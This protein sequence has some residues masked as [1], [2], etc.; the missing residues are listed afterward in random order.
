MAR[1]PEGRVHLQASAPPQKRP[2]FPGSMA[3]SISA[4]PLNAVSNRGA[5][6]A[7]SPTRCVPESDLMR[8]LALALLVV[9]SCLA[10]SQ[11]AEYQ[12]VIPAFTEET[13][14]AGIDSI[15]TG[16]WEFT[17]GGGVATFDCNADGF[18]DM[19]LAG[20]EAKAKFYRNASAKGGALKFEIQTSGLEL[21]KVTGAYPIDIDSDA[22]MDLVLLRV[23]ENTVMRGQGSCK[24]E[25]ANE[26]WGFIGGDGWSTIS[27]RHMGTRLSL[28]DNC[29]R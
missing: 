8:N 15:Y 26:D 5:A 20:G 25:R 6:S 13:K 14:S 27:G 23:G 16:D 17:V 1:R 28:A 29:H 2:A 7:H 24:F 3:A 12:P 18:S 19:L 22:M 11:A 21:D 10:S 9:V 4:P